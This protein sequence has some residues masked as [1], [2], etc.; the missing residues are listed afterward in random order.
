M[1]VPQKSV[2]EQALS[3]TANTTQNSTGTNY[4]A[5]AW[6]RRTNDVASGRFL[7]YLKRVEQPTT[8]TN[9]GVPLEA[10]VVL[11]I[12]GS[13]AAYKSPI[14]LRSLQRAGVR[15]DVVLTKA[16][17]QF[18]GQETFAGLLGRP[19]NTSMYG[20]EGGERHVQLA[21][22]ADALLIAPC[23]ADMM[24]RLA[25]GRADELLS[26]TALCTTAPI[27]LAPAMHP[28]M[29]DHPATQANAQL[30]SE[31]GVHFLGPT[32]GEVASGE[33]GLGRLMEPE[34]VADAALALLRGCAKDLSGRHVA[35]TAGPTVEDMDPVRFLTNRSSGKMGFALAAAATR[36][37]AKVSLIAG[38][39]DRSTPPGVERY[40]VRSALE[41]QQTL[42]RVASDADV[43]FMSAAVGDYRVNKPSR[44]K[45]KRKA[46]VTLELVA[47]PDIVAEFARKRTS[48]LPRVVAFAV[49]TGS[50]DLIIDRAQRKL[51]R[52]GAD[53]IIANRADEALGSDTNRVHVITEKS[54]E[55]LPVMNKVALA[56]LLLDRAKLLWLKT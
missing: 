16:A 45:L 8:H 1:R 12:T 2:G 48:L 37:G 15:V 50:D 26:A 30:L 9:S 49:E 35:V 25:Q 29:W 43:L 27:I 42:S 46:T 20:A 31:R 33:V 55:S 23:T 13:I 4:R 44:D 39:V 51:A 3:Q 41:L 7:G 17:Q 32:S 22:A 47:N 24:A 21:A 38:P 6:L 11:G 52:K 53:M 28:R 10:R 54:V 34:E 19:A 36:R 40:D 56:D 18:V 5:P 14:L